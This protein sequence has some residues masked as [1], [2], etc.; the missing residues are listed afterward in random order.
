MEVQINMTL[1]CRYC[2][3]EITFDDGYVSASGKMIPL[4]PHSEEPHKCGEY[5]V[6]RRNY[7]DC[8]KGCGKKIYFDEDYR[9]LTGKWIPVD[10]G[11]GQ[12]HQCPSVSE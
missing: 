11:T 5:E 8:R 2:D 6:A 7:H 9:T 1:Y 4:N 10:S 3:E 12:P